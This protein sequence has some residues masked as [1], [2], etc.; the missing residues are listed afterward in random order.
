MLGTL[1]TFDCDDDV[2]DCG[3]HNTINIKMSFRYLSTNDCI[4]LG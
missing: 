4:H 1:W 2:M 3:C